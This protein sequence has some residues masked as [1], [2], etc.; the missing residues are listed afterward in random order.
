MCLE[1]GAGECGVALTAVL[2]VALLVAGVIASALL[3]WQLLMMG[4][5][6]ALSKAQRMVENIGDAPGAVGRGGKQQRPGAGGL[7]P[8][9]SQCVE[10]GVGAR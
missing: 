7:L 1:L 5:Q 2:G 8:G 9:S 10:D 6:A 4:S 3:L